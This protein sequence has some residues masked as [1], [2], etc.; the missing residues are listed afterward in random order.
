MAQKTTDRWISKILA[1]PVFD[2][3][4]AK[5]VEV[6]P[7]ANL[8]FVS[9]I[10][11]SS[12]AEFVEISLNWGRSW[13]KEVLEVFRDRLLMLEQFWSIC[14]ASETAFLESTAVQLGF[15]LCELREPQCVSSR[16]SS[17]QSALAVLTSS[18]SQA[19]K[20]SLAGGV[21]PVS[22]TPLLDKEHA[23]KLKWAARLEAIGQRAG[24]HAKLFTEQD[25]S[26]NLTPGEMSKLRQLVLISGA[27]RT[28]AVHIKAYERFEKWAD[29]AQVTLYPLEVDKVLKYALFLDSQECGPSVIPSMKVSVK[30]VAS[31]LV[32]DLPDLDDRRLSSLQ[33]KVVTARATTLKEAIP[34]PLG[35]VGAMEAIAVNEACPTPMRVFVWWL[36]CMVYASLRFD[37]AV[38]VNP[39]ELIMMEEGLFGIA[40]QTKVDRKRAGTRFMVLKVGF[41]ESS[42]LEVGWGLMKYA[43]PD[44]RDFWVPELN[45]V[46]AFKEHAPTYQ[47][48]VQWLR[49][50]ARNA[51]DRRQGV[52]S[53]TI[54]EDAVTIS[55]LT[56]HSCR[57]TLLDAAVHA[58]RST[59]EI[60]LQA[61]WKNPGP[62]VLKYTRNRTQVP[63]VMIKQLV[64]ELVSTD[65]PARGD[66]DTLLTD[67][68]DQDLGVAEFFIKSPASGSRYEHRFHATALEDSSLIA[69]G[70]V[71][72]DECHSAGN[73]LPD[74][75]V[76]CKACAKQRPDLVPKE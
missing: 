5:A 57:V 54:H 53:K 50:F 2:E 9:A 66:K 60:G 26:D 32:I 22:S 68:A 13:D 7:L 27:H 39:K 75:S 51:S 25:Q 19:P 76:L 17:A 4:F 56:S 69:C 74:I 21:K 35:V 47:R 45:T 33:Q 1:L 16:A 14:K 15:G 67:V 37:D 29:H 40:W 49:Y 55:K 36:L 61:N 72:I 58:G 46:E 44:D 52:D 6:T 31:R 23:E 34:L 28:M 10:D 43:L 71:R 41:K 73:C 38:H 42:W 30:W 62:L 64:R 8:A 20:R 70:K 18:S 59:E 11:V 3:A 63:A 12:A 65:H 24:G 48:T